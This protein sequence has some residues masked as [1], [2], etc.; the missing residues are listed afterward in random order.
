MWVFFP[1]QLQQP[2]LDGL[3]RGP[4]FAH[5]SAEEVPQGIGTLPTLQVLA[6]GGAGD[7]G[8]M[9]LQCLR[10]GKPMKSSVIE[11]MDDDKIIRTIKK[12]YLLPSEM[13]RITLKNKE[14]KEIKHGLTVRVREG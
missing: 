12:R 7:G 11:F 3:L 5:G 6:L 10:Q 13:E 1:D 14:I 4:L 2:L 8:G 9:Q